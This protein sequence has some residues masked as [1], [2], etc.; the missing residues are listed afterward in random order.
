MNRVNTLVLIFIFSLF[1]INL[2]LGKGTKQILLSDAGHGKLSVMPSFSNFAWYT[3]VGGS[4]PADFRLHIHVQNIGEKI[5]Y[6]F[7]E[8]QNNNGTQVTDVVYRIKDPLGNIVVGPVAVPLAGAGCIST[9]NQAIAGPNAIV[10]AAGYPQ[11][12]Y[13]PL[14]TG[15]YFIE[16]NFKTTGGGSHDRTKFKYFDIT[17]ASAANQAIDGRVWSKAWQLT[18]DANGLTYAFNGTLYVYSADSIITS[19]YG[20][21]VAP[22]VFTI[23]CNQYGVYNTGNFANDRRSVAGNIILPE[24]KI[25]LNNPDSL[26]YPTGSLGQIVLPINLFP[27][28]DG[29]ATL[30]IKVTKPGDVDIFLDINP[31]PGAQPED[32]TLTAKVV[33]GINNIIWDG[34]DGLGNPVVNGYVFNVIVTYINGLTNL[35]IYDIDDHPNGYIINLHRPSGPVPQVFWDDILIGGT[36]N[37]TG[38]T[39]SLPSTGCHVVPYAQ[40]NNN[41]V[42]TWWYAATHTAAPVT[43]VEYRAPK[44]SAIYGPTGSCPNLMGCNVL[45]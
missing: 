41:T 38:C 18:A 31:L 35:P 27:N 2:A 6:G 13:T 11:L 32:R 20:N 39:Y 22:Y 16:F 44:I 29:T 34:L 26:V 25:F 12:T 1:S 40:G 8:P 28:C 21:G 19:V 43:F 3:T 10:G 9:F 7:G 45:L 15:D 36:Q 24:F 14:L 23:A 5:Y 17:V 37:F 42:N 33:A 30:Q 4:A